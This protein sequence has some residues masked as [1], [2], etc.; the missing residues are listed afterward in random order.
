LLAFANLADGSARSV[1]GRAAN[2][3]GVQASI[4]GGGAGT[5]LV[6]S[7]TALS[8]STLLSTSFA[9][10]TIALSR[11]A[12]IAALSVVANATNASASPTAVAGTADQV[13]RVSSAGTALAFGA[14]NLA[15]AAAVTGLLPFANIDDGVARSVFGR[16][17]NTSGVQASIAGGG[18]G[19]VLIDSGTALSFSTLL[20]TSFTDGTIALSRLVTVPAITVLGNATNATAAVTAIAGTTDQV[21]RVNAAGTGLGFGA[22]NLAA[23]AAVTGLLP[24]A[25]IANGSARS[26]LGRSANTAGVQASIAGGGAGTVLID[27]G[28]TLSFSTLLSTSFT[29]GTIALSRLVTVS[30]LSVLANATASTAAVTA[31]AGTADQVLRVNSGGTA[32]GFGAVNLA[33]AAAVTGLLPFANIADGSARSVFGRSANTS[34]VQASIAGAGAGTVLIDNGTTLSF[35]TIGASSIGDGTLPLTKL[36][37]GTACS[38]VGRSANTT[39]AYADISIG[40]NDH[41]LM[42]TANVVTSG[43]VADANVS[44]TAAIAGTKI[45]PNFGSQ[46]VV[47]TGAY[48]AGTN[49]AT[50]GAYNLANATDIRGRNAA[51][52]ADAIMLRIDSSD[53]VSVG[54][55]AGT[56]IRLTTA[57]VHG[58]RISGTDAMTLS[59][60]LLTVTAAAVSIAASNAAA[61]GNI[62]LANG[63]II[64]GRNNANTA[65]LDMLTTGS[66]DQIILG[67]SSDCSVLLASQNVLLRPAGTDRVQ[68]TDTV[69]EWRLTTVRFDVAVS[70]PVIQQE[71]DTTTA[72][73]ADTLTLAGQDA[74]GTGATVGGPLNLRGG[75]STTGTGGAFDVRS[76]AGASATT[77]GAFTMRIGSTVFLSWAGTAPVASQGALRLA[78]Q[79]GIYSRNNANSAD[80][81]L[82]ITNSGDGVFVGDATNSSSMSLQTSGSRLILGT[83]IEIQNSPQLRFDSTVASPN[84][85]HEAD[86]TTAVTGDLFLVQA[87]N[88]T[89]TGAT[90][91]GIMSVRGGDSTTGTGGAIDLRSGVGATSTTRGDFLLRLGND[92]FMSMPGTNPIATSG[93]LRMYHGSTILTGRD[94]GNTTNAALMRWGVTTNDMLTLGNTTY[95]TEMLGA[96]VSIGDGSTY[97][98]LAVLA[99][100]REVLSLMLGSNI[101]TTEMPA[102]TGD[103]VIFLATA[104]TAPSANPSSAG[105]IVYAN[106]GAFVT[107]NNSGQMLLGSTSTGTKLQGASVELGT[108]VGSLTLFSSGE[109]NLGNASGPPG[110]NPG[111]GVTFFCIAGE[112]W[113]RGGAGTIKKLAEA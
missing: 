79:A 61:S 27:S 81:S 31:V 84:I 14:I 51:N 100:N 98:E 112:L 88:V 21:M 80:V 82:L 60:S 7:G 54:D 77:A 87:Q 43:F 49:P 15:A 40:T 113:V 46:T 25:N 4:A 12:S 67:N 45:S 68:V 28:T 107:R 32:L 48:R 59:S 22:I 92:I 38:V 19:T 109:L 41:V 69:F 95:N 18:A 10:G 1:I 23:S 52:S 70:N 56:G 53:T 102:N 24:F 16:A 33:A 30:A 89:G 20:S 36:A 104:T 55:V 29:D 17:A 72:V 90:V 106:S 105:I 34:G 50:S 108:S 35:A 8:F 13:L 94:S 85:I 86:T 93:N 91:G 110:S 76:G 65:D 11:L 58:F 83:N 66:T 6:D 101:T 97:L 9:D 111:S 63:G 3:S 64:R 5:V 37:N 71:S 42:R 26:V 96:T 74:T 39:G 99:T 44:A 78:S 103:K 75:N 73:T 47:T 2:T 62:R 57:G